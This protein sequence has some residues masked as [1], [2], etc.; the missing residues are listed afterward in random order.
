MVLLLVPITRRVVVVDDVSKCVYI[1]NLDENGCSGWNFNGWEFV[2]PDSPPFFYINIFRNY[3]FRFFNENTGYT[4]S[5]QLES[6]MLLGSTMSIV[7][8]VTTIFFYS[9]TNYLA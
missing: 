3:L 1:Y 9:F 2:T 8:L 7:D 4:W 6:S 5:D